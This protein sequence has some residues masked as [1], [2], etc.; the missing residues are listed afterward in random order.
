MRIAHFSRPSRP[1]TE[2]EVKETR[3]GFINAAP[4]IRWFFFRN[5]NSSP[6]VIANTKRIESIDKELLSY[7]PYFEKLRLPELGHAL[8]MCIW[9]GTFGR[10]HGGEG[11]K[12][13]EDDIGARGLHISKWPDLFRDQHITPNGRLYFDRRR[14]KPW[15]TKYAAP[16]DW[17]QKQFTNQFWEEEMKDVGPSVLR[18]PKILGERTIWH[19]WVDRT[20]EVYEDHWSDDSSISRHEDDDNIVRPGQPPRLFAVAPIDKGYFI[21]RLPEP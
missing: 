9:G 10:W 1:L 8:E 16:M 17:I 15:L 4:S 3:E 7:K 5:L 14:H 11:S 13:E 12:G 6:V 2:E 18:T 19:T 20:D 21:S